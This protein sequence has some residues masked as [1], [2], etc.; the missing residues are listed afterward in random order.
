MGR[1]QPERTAAKPH[2]RKRPTFD[3]SLTLGHL[4]EAFE[5][6]ADYMERRVYLHGD[7]ERTV[8]VCYLLGMTRNER[9]SDY[10]L[11]PL[12]QDAAL[13][14]I[15][16][17]ELF[18]RLQYG[19]LYNMAATRRCVLDDVVDDL[20]GGSCALFFPQNP[21]VLTL[22]VP[23]EEKRGVGEP[24]N[25]PALK[26]VRES[27][28]ESIRTNTAMI[29]RHLRAPHL[30]IGEHIVGRQS[31]TE[32]DVIYLDGIADP[33]LVEGI[34]RRLDSI[35][36]DGV[37]AAGNLEEY[38]T[39]HLNTPFPTMP[40]TQRPDRF[41]QGLLEGRV[42]V[43]ADGLPMGWLL[44]GT[45]DQFFK[46]G[47]DRAF[48]WM[49]A[50]ALNLI[51]WFCALVTVLLPGLY[52]AVVTFHPEAIPVKLALSIAA[53]K[54]EVP[55]S[56]VFEVLIMLLAFEVLQEAGLRLPGPIGSTV[57]ILGGLVVGNAAV[58]AHIVS[59]AVLVAVAIAGVAGYTMPSQDFAA[60]LR[61]WRFALAIVASIAGVFGLAAGCAALIY[62]LASLETF[63]IPYLAPFTNGAE[64]PKGHPNL[65]R[66]PLPSMKWRDGARHTR[67]RRNQ[68]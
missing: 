22:P 33:E 49:T 68:R 43:M 51:R 67:N 27:F 8:T 2:P 37:E 62:H 53:A 61:L 12:A 19:A 66:P 31:R 55:F 21:D 57:S 56:T 54:Q 3:Q 14:E 42:G 18:K 36:I 38:L 16:E 6:C 44:P 46:T 34:G 13:S 45:I 30:K 25:E 64:Q 11:R 39:D 9:L 63:G 65:L 47:Q 48:H 60:A 40:F 17:E 52:I 29:R 1:F 26:G 50:S 32:V 28:V 58:D 41:C 4:K 59:P 5:G 24:E 20:I 7:S 10:V 23:T 35:D 15:P